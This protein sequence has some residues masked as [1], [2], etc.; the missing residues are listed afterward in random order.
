[1]ATFVEFA[2]GQLPLPIRV[3]RKKK[4]AAFCA[5]TFLLRRGMPPVAEAVWRQHDHPSTRFRDGVAAIFFKLVHERGDSGATGAD[6]R[7][8]CNQFLPF[9]RIG[10]GASMPFDWHEHRAFQ[11][12]LVAVGEPGAAEELHGVHRRETAVAPLPPPGP[13]GVF[14]DVGVKA[15]ELSLALDDPVVPLPLEDGAHRALLGWY[16]ERL[17]VGPCEFSHENRHEA[18]EGHLVA[19]VS[20]ADEE[21]DVVGH[22]RHGVERVH[23]QRVVG[24]EKDGCAKSLCDGCILEER[25]GMALELPEGCCCVLREYGSCA[26]PRDAGKSVKPFSL[27]QSD[28]VEVGQAV[29]EFWQASHGGKYSERQA[30]PQG[31]RTRGVKGK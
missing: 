28:H 5:E 24:K 1:M 22:D 8:Q 15:L 2:I 6:P 11:Q 4:H 14:E 3:E 19:R 31:G 27:L 16:A 30:L 21:V 25:L 20:Y 9:G 13:E 26:F 29:V 23:A 7:S 10:H 12:L 18:A 17:P